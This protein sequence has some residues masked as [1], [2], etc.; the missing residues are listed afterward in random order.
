M[1][2]QMI[3]WP[4]TS[5]WGSFASVNAFPPDRTLS[6]VPCRLCNTVWHQTLT[7][8]YSLWLII[9]HCPKYHAFCV[10]KQPFSLWNIGRYLNNCT[11]LSLHGTVL[12][13]ENTHIIG[14]S[15]V[16]PDNILY[17][18]QTFLAQKY[19]YR[20]FPPKI[21]AVEFEKIL[22][23]VSKADDKKLLTD[24]FVRDDNIVPPLYQLTPIRQKLP[25]Y[26]NDDNPE[27]KSKVESYFPF[28]A[29]Q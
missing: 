16:T 15:N 23:G 19:G 26:A 8:Q 20:P 17:S 10:C 24:W 18:F 21:D 6:W 2:P 9:F 28:C 5:V 27:L 4:L 12:R 13:H 3:T 14:L 25:D 1:R 7:N 11:V 22:S 29:I